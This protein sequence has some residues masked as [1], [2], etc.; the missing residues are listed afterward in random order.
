MDL[1]FG[2][3]VA[4]VGIKAFAILRLVSRT[5]L[6]AM[7]EHPVSPMKPIAVEDRT[8]V[9]K[10]V[11]LMPQ[12]ERVQLCSMDSS[13]NLGPLSTLTSLTQLKIEGHSKPGQQSETVAN[14]TSLPPTLR[15]L[16][17]SCV[18]IP[19]SHFK[20]MKCCLIIV[21]RLKFGQALQPEI[22]RLLNLLPE[23][24]VAL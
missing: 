7:T 3:L 13:I 17:L 6:A 1:I 5:W 11:Q 10:L 2:E 15:E 22:G 9:R 19:P 8:N 18:Q 14:L 23:L 12:M 16:Q 20:Y 4:R 21:L 24:K